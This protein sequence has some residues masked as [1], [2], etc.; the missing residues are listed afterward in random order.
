M[1]NLR[2]PPDMLSSF[3]LVYRSNHPSCMLAFIRGSIHC[4]RYPLDP[5]MHTQT[6][7]RYQLPVWLC[8]DHKPGCHAA[9]AL[10]ADDP[11]AT[12]TVG[13]LHAEWMG[14]GQR[15][16]CLKRFYR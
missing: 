14:E 3:S 5:S 1:D 16:I 7:L 15:N 6:S 10:G 11:L 4:T 2:T 9:T 12:R 13:T 8:E